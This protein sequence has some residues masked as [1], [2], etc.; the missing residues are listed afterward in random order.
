MKEIA[1]QGDKRMTVKEVAESLNVSERTIQRH[2]EK[3]GMTRN[4]FTTWLSESDVT[5]IKIAIEAS[6]RSDL[7]N[8]VE[9]KNVH[10]DLEMAMKA[11]EVMAWMG[12]K[13]KTL[14]V[15]V[16][17]ARPKV[18]F[19]DAVTE[20]TDTI[21]MA[22]VAK[23]L[24]IPGFGRN[25]IF[26]FLRGRNILMDGNKPYQ[27]YINR[28]YFKLVEYSYEDTHGMTHV[29]LKPVVYQKGLDFIRKIIMENN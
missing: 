10:T 17:A 20:S 29:G 25:N 2:A 3:L 18:A 21:D 14:Q 1:N 7:A 12:E 19:F 28:G 23:V 15:E 24:N 4:G 22:E 13:I 27:E 5:R 16:E 6:G 11:Q 9:V 26:A 8:V